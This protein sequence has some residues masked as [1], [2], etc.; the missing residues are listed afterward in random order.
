MNQNRFPSGLVAGI[1]VALFFGVALYLRIAL[2][3]DQVF[4]GDWIKFTGVDAYFFMRLVDNLVHNFPHLITFDPYLLYPGGSGI[5]TPP[6]WIY[7]LSGVTWLIGLGSPTQHTVDMVGV[8]FPA[9]L[10]A[11]TTIPV[12]FIG[13]ALFNRWAGAIAAGLVAI[14]PGEFLG[15]STL[16][17][18]D[19]HVAE[20]L[21]TTLI[22]LFL[23]LAV[24][25]GRDK[26]LTFGS[27]WHKQWADLVLC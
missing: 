26:Q 17:F 13:K 21:L 18:T 9:V 3:Y 15:R 23:I 12:Y 7:L 1:I 11:L 22:M 10:G 4:V 20:V 25:A 14:F 2:P 19:Y 8:Y 27:L 5:G 16:G 6:F 24:K